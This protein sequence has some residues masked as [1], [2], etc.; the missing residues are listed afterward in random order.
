MRFPKLLTP[1]VCVGVCSIATLVGLGANESPAARAKAKA[2]PLPAA[3]LKSIEVRAE[4]A[5]VGFM[6]EALD[7]AKEYED[8]GEFERAKVM[9]DAILRLEPDR[10]GLKEKIQKLDESILSTNEAEF[11]L[12]VAAGW[13]QPVA[14]V[15]KDRPV[16]FTTDGDYKLTIS[17]KA[18]ANG[19]P[20][21]NPTTDLLGN[22]PVGALI[23]AVY[24]D[25]KPG[26]PFLIGAQHDWTPDRDG[27]LMLKVNLPQGHKSTGRIKVTIS[28][29]SLRP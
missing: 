4:K 28:G 25:N 26:K 22:V 5:Q 1:L 10:P 21:E 7:I 11:D 27:L 14:R 23:G 8:A 18:G 19:L 2:K 15:F 17:Q 12:D 16:R 13:S 6:R 24:V 9:Y 20:T 29:Y 3:A